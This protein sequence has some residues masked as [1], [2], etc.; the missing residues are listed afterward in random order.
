MA[1]SIS[2]VFRLEVVDFFFIHFEWN[3]SNRDDLLCDKARKARAVVAVVAG[4]ADDD[5]DAAATT[6]S[7]QDNNNFFEKKSA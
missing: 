4:A 7:F 2:L 3:P 6:A 5:D 1:L